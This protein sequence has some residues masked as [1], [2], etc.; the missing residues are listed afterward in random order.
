VNLAEMEESFAARGHQDLA[1]IA[2]LKRET[3]ALLERPES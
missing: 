3:L 2:H 1:Q